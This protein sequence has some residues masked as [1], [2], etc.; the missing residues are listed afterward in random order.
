[1]HVRPAR[2]DD[3][4]RLQAIEVA[5]GALFL[6]TDFP[7][8]AR[9][10]PPAAARLAA[11]A[12]VLVAVDGDDTPLGYAQVELV[13]GGAHLEQLSVDPAFGRHGIGASL[14]DAVWAWAGTNGHDSVTLTT[15]RDVPF[16]RPYYERRGFAVVPEAA[17]SPALRAL[18]ADEAT[19]GLDPESRVVML[20][21]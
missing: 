9:D 2:P 1:M 20:R 7:E 18:V 17:W 4:A 16:N 8:V 13:G 15:F 14:L 19:H 12:A 10:E 5:A 21:R 6:G 11:A 3:T